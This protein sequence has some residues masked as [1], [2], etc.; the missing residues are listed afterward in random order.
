[1]IETDN[2]RDLT[3]IHQSDWAVMGNVTSSQRHSLYWGAMLLLMLP[4]PSHGW[5]M[6]FF[7]FGGDDHGG[8]PTT[9]TTT[10]TTVNGDPP[11][12][13]RAINDRNDVVGSSAMVSPAAPLVANGGGVSGGGGG[14]GGVGVHRLSAVLAPMIGPHDAP[15]LRYIPSYV[16]PKLRS[17]F[18]LLV[19]RCRSAR[20]VLFNLLWYKPPVGIVGAWSALRV[21]ERLYHAVIRPPPPNSG[22]EALAD[23]EDRLGDSLRSARNIDKM[24]YRRRRRKHNVRRGRSLDL[25]CGDRSYDMFGGIET[26]RVR[27]CQEGLKSALAISAV[28]GRSSTSSSSSRS[29]SNRKGGFVTEEGISFIDEDNDDGKDMSAAASQYARDAETAIGALRLSCP[30]RGSREYFVERSAEALSMLGGYIASSYGNGNGNGN[31]SGGMPSSSSSSAHVRSVKLLLRHSSKLI[32]LR[33]LDALLRTLRDRHLIVASRMR[34]ECDFWRFRV[35]LSGGKIGMFADAL[36]KSV[37]PVMRPW[38]FGDNVGGGDY[39]MQYE[40]ATASFERELTCLG[41]A[42]GLLLRRPGE[43]DVGDLLDVPGFGV[44]GVNRR[45]SSLPR[46]GFG[47]DGR[48]RADENG[49]EESERSLMR[50]MQLLSQPKNRMWLQQTEK[51]NREARGVIKDSLIETISSSFTPVDE[52]RGIDDYPQGEV[53][54]ESK[55]LKKW[56]SYDG[57]ASDVYSWLMVLSLVDFAASPKR[58]GERKWYFQLS[59]MLKQYDFLGIPSSALFLAAANS[60]HDNVIAP[61]KREI[62]DFIKSILNAIWGIVEFRFYAP[63]KDIVLDLLN[64]RPRMV[65]PF[66]LLNEQISLDNMLMDLGVGD[67][68]RQTRAA[69]LASVSR[70]Y[71]QELSSGTIRGILRGRVAQLMLIQIQQLKSDLLQAMDS[72]DNLIDAN[73]LNVQLVAS[74]PAVLII[75]YGTRVLFLFWSNIRIKDFRLP[76]DVHAEMSDYLK[77]VEECLVLSNYQLDGPTMEGAGGVPTAPGVVLS[78]CLGP[79]E[80]G[81]LLLLLHSY[82]NLLDYMSPPFP[83][84][85]CDSIH[86]SMQN[87]LVQGNMSTPRQLGLHERKEASSMPSTVPILGDGVPPPQIRHHRSTQPAN[88]SRASLLTLYR[89]S[90]SLLLGLFLHAHFYDLSMCMPRF[91]KTV[92]AS[93]AFLLPSLFLFIANYSNSIALDRIGISLTYTSKCGIPL[94]TVLF[95]LLLDGISALPSS[96]T[97]LSLVPIALGIGASSWNSPTFELFGFLA[98]LISTTSQ[99]ALNVVSKRVM[100]KTGVQ[101]VEAQ[102]AM[103]FVALGIGLFMTAVSGIGEGM[104]DRHKGD[105]DPASTTGNEEMAGP[106]VPVVP[107]PAHPPFWLTCLAVLAYHVEYV[108]SFSFV[109]MV[110]PITYGTCDALRRLLIIV[111]G[112]QLFGGAK[113]SNLNLGGMIMALFGAVM[114]SITSAKSGGAIRP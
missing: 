94:I 17:L 23:A 67:G 36:R 33:V 102:R 5:N 34:R 8:A 83:G 10:T 90:G 37:L 108:L 15:H 25:D 84:K 98:A 56:A 20:I 29:R 13:G 57:G 79:K 24:R 71:E 87:L 11:G 53:Y 40:L 62:L 76:R 70:M 43:M 6:P 31:G 44:E 61:H 74:I 105:N 12:L 39:Q 22:E 26:V 99:A 66:A 48:K 28:N 110:E 88:L 72:I 95:T 103:V 109:S 113:F 59:S 107:P 1:M 3:D 4:S 101:G 73:R 45:I 16:P 75:I 81:Q 111:S 7:G 91:L 114:F 65:D 104:R 52:S 78:S 19:D 93:K 41:I 60:L 63:I 54:A 92:N 106:A 9:T 96:A 30:P 46:P 80:M 55:F 49:G 68:T 86:L 35:N 77:K 38:L 27:A 82:L 21:L 32:E 58:A 51:W 97:L 18:P 50:T 100:K 85:T 47:A 112:K 42:E 64:R 14:G 89:F 69:A 2:E